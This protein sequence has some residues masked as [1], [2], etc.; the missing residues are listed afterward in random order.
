MRRGRFWPPSLAAGRHDGVME[1]IPDREMT[2]ASEVALWGHSALSGKPL[3]LL[4][5]SRGGA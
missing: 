5:L 4:D 2:D 3:E 1:I